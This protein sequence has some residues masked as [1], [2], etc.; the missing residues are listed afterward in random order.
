MEE[1]CDDRIYKPT[2]FSR[3]IARRKRKSRQERKRYKRLQK[4]KAV[5]KEQDAEL[6]RT[7]VWLRDMAGPLSPLK[8]SCHK[9]RV[10]WRDIESVQPLD[11]KLLQRL[12]R[13]KNQS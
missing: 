2:T 10:R 12:Y 11:W 1:L 4:K 3:I 5:Q 13:Q 7:K 9:G 8:T 6:M